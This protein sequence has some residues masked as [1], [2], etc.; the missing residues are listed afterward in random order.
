MLHRLLLLIAVMD[1]DIALA[2]SPYIKSSSS[3]SIVIVHLV[4]VKLICL[5][6]ACTFIC[7]RILEN[8]SYGHA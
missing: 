8:H 2:R 7:D 1:S 3:S 6:C 4:F 5:Y